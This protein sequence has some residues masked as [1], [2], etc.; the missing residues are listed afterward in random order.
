[1]MRM[2]NER[3]QYYEQ[4]KQRAIE[5]AGGPKSQEQQAAFDKLQAELDMRVAEGRAQA[6][7][8]AA[9][10]VK[11]TKHIE[12]REGKVIGGGPLEPSAERIPEDRVVV[13]PDGKAYAA[14]TPAEALEARKRIRLERELSDAQERIRK[15][16]D[17]G[18][19]SR[20]IDKLL[21]WEDPE[22]KALHA[23]QADANNAASQLA[24]VE[25][26]VRFNPEARE[27]V[28]DMIGG[29]NPQS[30]GSILKSAWGGSNDE[31]SAAERA[32]NARERATLEGLRPI[33]AG[34]VIEKGR[35][36]YRAQE[37]GESPKYS[38]HKRDIERGDE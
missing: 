4:A 23:A 24:A 35:T 3:V 20:I 14:P 30:W 18:V 31:L 1:M 8:A 16:K 2:S 19:T 37:T 17:I 27:H 12:N 11:V 6:Q 5:L 22:E 15:Y 38:T 34:S 32:A 10:L 7:Q 13:T 29:S 28:K 33:R 21:P 25:G 36:T 9:G 26:R